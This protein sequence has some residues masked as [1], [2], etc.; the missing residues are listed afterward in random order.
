MASSKNYEL[1]KQV[2]QK[3]GTWQCWWLS[4]LEAARDSEKLDHTF[5]DANGTLNKYWQGKAIPAEGELP[6]DIKAK[7]DTLKNQKPPSKIVLKES[8]EVYGPVWQRMIM[9]FLWDIGGWTGWYPA[10]T[11]MSTSL[12]PAALAKML[13]SLGVTG[14]GIP[15]KGAKMTPVE[16]LKTVGGLE[17]GTWVLMDKPGHAMSGRVVPVAAPKKGACPNQIIGYNQATEANLTCQVT[18]DK[19]GLS[20]LI[21]TGTT[22]EINWLLPLAT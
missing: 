14:I 4:L 22:T 5:N 8:K 16:V 15:E 13:V 18:T 11:T 3:D 10:S 12:R 7:N 20:H 19:N 21:V 6:P 2:I 17:P 1:D 9:Y